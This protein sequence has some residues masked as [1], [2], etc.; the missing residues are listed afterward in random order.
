[1]NTVYSLQKHIVFW[2]RGRNS[3]FVKD[4]TVELLQRKSLLLLKSA[5]AVPHLS[6]LK[7]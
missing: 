3:N 6:F 7:Q 5:K 4:S 1:M 2:Y